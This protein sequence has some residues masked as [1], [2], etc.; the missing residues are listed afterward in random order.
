[1]ATPLN[2]PG[3][4]ALIELPSESGMASVARTTVRAVLEACSGARIAGRDLDEISVVVQEACTNAIRHAHHL[5]ASK[6]FRVEVFQ[7]DDR[8]EILV[9]DGGAPFA[10]SDAPMPEPE[11][12]RE[13]GYGVHIMR[14]WMDEVSVRHDGTG[15]VLRLV[16][17]L[18]AA[19]EAR[20]DAGAARHV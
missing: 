16:R 10:L 3:R 12:L 14:T 5:D 2:P 15:N 11:H 9:S 7:E 13:G 6:A 17:R 20:D 19:S 8:V 4:A 18:G 1:M